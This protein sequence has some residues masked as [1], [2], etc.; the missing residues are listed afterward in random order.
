M[1]NNYLLNHLHPLIEDAEEIK[2]L[3]NINLEIRT[4]ALGVEISL[5][6]LLLE[7]NKEK[8]KVKNE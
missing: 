7:L 1:N 3:K 6:K 8:I 4:A 5:S 2:N